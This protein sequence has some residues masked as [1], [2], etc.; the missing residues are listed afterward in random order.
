MSNIALG[1]IFIECNH[2]GGQPAGMEAFR[3]GGL[4]YDRELLGL[5][6]GTIGGM[7]SV[8]RGR[9]C[10][11]S[12]LLAASACPSGPLSEGCWRELKHGLIDRLR[13]AA[14]VD[15]V[16]LALHGAAAAEGAGDLEGDL[17]EAVRGV[18][19]ASVPIVATLDL[20]AHVTQRMIGH[21]DALLAWE[22]YP[23]ADAYSTGERGARTLLAILNGELKPR[24][25]MAKVPVMVGAIHGHTERPGPF[26]DVMVHGKARE[27]R[28]GIWSVSCFLVHPYLDLPDMG[29]GALVISN[30][31]MV[32]ASGLASELAAMY[33]DR[34]HELEP[35]LLTA[36]VAVARGLEIEGGPVV[37]AE[38]ADCCGG[39]AA[40]DSVH[41]L[42]AILNNGG[43]SAIVPV[44]DP[45][46]ATECHLAG[47]GV[48]LRLRLG[49]QVDRQWGQP[50]EV[51]GEVVRLLDGGFT[52]AGGIWDGQR[53]DMGRAAV[54]MAGT[55][56]VLIA[57]H[58]TYDWGTE[59][60]DAAGLDFSRVKF[61]VAKNPMNFRRAF[62]GVM[63]AALVLDTP[64]PTPATV[65]HL[66]FKNMRR[67]WFPLDAEMAD[68]QPVIL[69]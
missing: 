56:Q 58:A 12:P 6:T 29:G 30:G 5:E 32:A 23:H 17:L 16:L 21:A 15:G 51:K 8:L 55:V 27:G 48:A 31:D 24:M 10:K 39:G 19:G 7:L 63:K 49:H 47:V 37:L 26:A 41:A 59:Q 64:G 44:V 38:T 43:A 53:G 11:V 4:F 22:T 40:G 14:P 50:M 54:F 57:T 18:V 36:E 67:P 25:A 52:Y 28:D 65:R 62:G 3:R 68:P 9:G 35:R 46:A 45:G 13:N 42:R 69:K 34:R 60:L 20:H 1:S 2:F 66:P 33:W 61:V